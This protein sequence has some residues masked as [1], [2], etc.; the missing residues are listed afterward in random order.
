MKPKGVIVSDNEEYSLDEI[1]LLLGEKKTVKYDLKINLITSSAIS[2]G[3]LSDFHEVV[4]DL[5]IREFIICLLS[6]M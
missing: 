5:D 1:K 2:M 6:K 4:R 3:V